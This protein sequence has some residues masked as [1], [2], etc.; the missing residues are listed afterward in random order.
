MTT[1]QELIA[2]ME[3]LL[4]TQGREPREWPVPIHR[5]DLEELLDAYC[6]FELLFTTPMGI[7]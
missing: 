3:L 7:I 5:D 1:A 2:R 6:A 4:Q